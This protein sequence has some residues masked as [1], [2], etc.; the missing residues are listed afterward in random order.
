M[1]MLILYTLVIRDLELAHVLLTHVPHPANILTL[2][3]ENSDVDRVNARHV[4]H[5]LDLY[6]NIP[7]SLVY[8]Q[9]MLLIRLL[10]SLSGESH[11]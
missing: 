1:Y 3:T 4:V 6:K 5:Y 10:T 9:K 11:V 2:G 7:V 8:I